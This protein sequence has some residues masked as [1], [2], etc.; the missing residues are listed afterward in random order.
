MDWREW[1]TDFDWIKAMKENCPGML[2]AIAAV[3]W[4]ADS[5]CVT[6]LLEEAGGD[7][8]TIVEI[9]GDWVEE[10]LGYDSSEQ[11]QEWSD[12]CQVFYARWGCLELASSTPEWDEFWTNLQKEELKEV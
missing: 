5:Y 3:Q 6:E 11:W 4:F 1:T 8:D 7:P 12:L 2:E 9:V 10:S